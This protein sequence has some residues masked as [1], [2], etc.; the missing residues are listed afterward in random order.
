M[1]GPGHII[2]HTDSTT[3][4]WLARVLSVNGNDLAVEISSDTSG[5]WYEM[6]NYQHTLAG[7]RHGEY[8]IVGK[9]GDE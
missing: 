1:I 5:V 7:L 2:A 3:N 6:W 9:K 4:N 8:Y